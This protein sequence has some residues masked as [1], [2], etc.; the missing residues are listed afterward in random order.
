MHRRKF[1]SILGL[2]GVASATTAPVAAK[3]ASTQDFSGHPDAFGVLHDS[4]L[5]I[6]C[7][8][9]EQGCAK[10]NDLP[11]PEKPFDDLTVL[12]E[13]RRTNFQS[14]TVVNK[15]EVEINGEKKTIFRKQ[16]CN[17]CQEPA[18]AS[19]CFVK[20]FT[21]NADGSVTYNPNNCVGCRYCM[22]ACPFYIPTY[23]Y[24]NVW[25]PLV[26]K[27]TMCAP[28]IQEGKLPGC[29]EACP[30]GA[31][32]FGKRSELVRLAWSRIN[33]KPELYVNR[34]YGENEMGGTNW[35]YITQ[36]APEELGLPALSRTSAP[37]LTSGALGSVA[38]VA[39]MWPV[40]LGGA[41]AI[42]KRKE[43]VAAEEQ[44]EAVQGA[45]EQTQ[46]KAEEKLS[47]ALA[48]A[49]KE[50]DALLAKEAAKVKALEEKVAAL[51]AAAAPEPEEEASAPESAGN[52]PGT[53]EDA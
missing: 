14:Y 31:L 47:A 11:A 53:K 51:E 52:E 43:K 6:G 24:H 25:N 37:E 17:H 15:Y 10:V 48:K 8:K 35:L 26:Y 5:C 33:K 19:A 49:G 42:T 32:V 13:K 41:Y 2:A 34:V 23:D 28:R 1:L 44:A 36:A 7:R 45:V 30:Q 50:R 3:A 46:A 40:L 29:V 20:A 16:Q 39:G 4:T 22:V 18:C 9:C 27:C 21:K 12:D 38:M